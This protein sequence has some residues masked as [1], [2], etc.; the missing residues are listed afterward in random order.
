MTAVIAPAKSLQ[1]LAKH[2]AGF[3][4]IQQQAG[5]KY[6]SGDT[7]ARLLQERLQCVRVNFDPVRKYSHPLNLTTEFS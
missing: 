6:D 4:N 5:L 2:G 3:T 7:K 1:E